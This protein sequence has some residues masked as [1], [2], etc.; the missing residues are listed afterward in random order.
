MIFKIEV[1]EIMENFT[2]E[3]LPLKWLK[4]K[5]F[6]EVSVP[7]HAQLKTGQIVVNKFRKHYILQPSLR[8]HNAGRH[9]KGS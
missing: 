5:N 9:I 4:Y 6:L 2:S 7:W 1:D 3:G 8:G